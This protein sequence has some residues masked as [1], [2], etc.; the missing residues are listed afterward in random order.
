MQVTGQVA[1]QMLDYKEQSETMKSLFADAVQPKETEQAGIHGPS[2]WTW[3]QTLAQSLKQCEVIE[4]VLW[5][6]IKEF[7]LFHASERRQKSDCTVEYK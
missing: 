4:D 5:R 3:E 6:Q 7:C 2:R 1:Y